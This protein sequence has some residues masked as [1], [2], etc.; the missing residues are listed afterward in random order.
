MRI[1][2]L[3]TNMEKLSKSFLSEHEQILLTVTF[4]V[5]LFV[6][7]SLKALLLT[8]VLIALGIGVWYLGVP[9]LWATLIPAIIWFFFVFIH[10]VTAFIDWKYDV[11]LVTTEEVVIID[12]TSLFHV[13]IRQLTLDNIASVSAES[14]FWNVLPFG[15]LHFDLKEGISKAFSLPYIPH[16]RVVATA[17]SDA[18]VKFQRRRASTPS[19]T[20]PSSSQ[21]SQK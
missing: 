1:F 18:V 14:Q 15:K 3:E 20:A 9:G 11:L 21:P 8:T 4:S 12:Q 13:K 7:R 16:A 17:I 5:F 10:W 19:Q 2:A 6:I